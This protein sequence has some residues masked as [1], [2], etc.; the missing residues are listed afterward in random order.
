[1][2]K[3]IF[4]VLLV[5]AIIISSA[6]CGKNKKSDDKTE[7][8]SGGKQAVEQVDKETGRP[9]DL[10]RLPNRT[11]PTPV[12]ITRRRIMLHRAGLIINPGMN[13]FHSTQR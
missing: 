1:M 11:K 4:A 7:Q 6:A 13:C 2:V 8:S 10:L 5:I 12:K 9:T 3:K